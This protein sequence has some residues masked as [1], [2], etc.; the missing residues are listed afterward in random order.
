MSLSIQQPKISGRK[1][2]MF[3]FRYSRPFLIFIFF[4]VFGYGL[5]VWHEYAYRGEWSDE[6]KVQYSETAFEE[7]VFREEAFDRAVGFFEERSKRHRQAVSVNRDYF[8]PDTER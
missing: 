6:R 7:T 4:L 1:I 5:F 3:L 2:M 8:F